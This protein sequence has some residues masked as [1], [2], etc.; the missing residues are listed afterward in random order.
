[1]R[2]NIVANF[3]QLISSKSTDKFGYIHQQIEQSISANNPAFS[4]KNI[5]Q[6]SSAIFRP[7]K[8]NRQKIVRR[9]FWPPRF[10]C[11]H[12]YVLQPKFLPV[13]NIGCKYIAPTEGLLS[14]K[15]GLP[16]FFAFSPP[17]H[18]NIA[19]FLLLLSE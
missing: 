3:W 6:K 16:V 14:F 5:L 1:M 18:T 4:V 17:F 10:L 11:G 2:A 12:L 13:G 9:F 15:I 19:H 7:F 8:Q